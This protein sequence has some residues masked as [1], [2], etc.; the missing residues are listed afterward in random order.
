M[1]DKKRVNHIFSTNGAFMGT[2]EDGSHFIW[3][4]NN[5]GAFAGP[6]SAFAMSNNIQ[7]IYSYCEPYRKSNLTALYN[8]N[9]D[10]RK[11]L[12]NSFNSTDKAQVVLKSDGTINTWGEQTHGA[13]SANTQNT[14][15]NLSN[16]KDIATGNDTIVTLKSDGTLT[17]WNNNTLT[18][19]DINSFKG[20]QWY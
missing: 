4:K 19:S 1:A 11:V 20:S 13:S 7:D 12:V 2:N 10:T 3:G 5:F 14:I 18:L 6:V 16:V 9:K 8:V 15:N 17:A